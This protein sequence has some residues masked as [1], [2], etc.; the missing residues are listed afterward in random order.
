MKLEKRNK[1]L[2]GN[3]KSGHEFKS[4]VDKKSWKQ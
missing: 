1:R 2:G 3:P 4:G